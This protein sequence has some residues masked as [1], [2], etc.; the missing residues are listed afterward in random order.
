M[1]PKQDS[2]THNPTN[3]TMEEETT[4]QSILKMIR[5]RA[6]NQ[7]LSD[8]QLIEKAGV[9]QRAW[10]LC[11]NPEK[12]INQDTLVKLA[13]AVGLRLELRLIDPEGIPQEPS[14][15]TNR[16]ATGQ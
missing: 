4:E 11:F 6:M 1:N 5:L 8:N 15:V 12:S 16:D 14:T 7:G 2:F 10:N 3:K 9:T 13:T